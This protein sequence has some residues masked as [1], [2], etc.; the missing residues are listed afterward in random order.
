MQAVHVPQEHRGPVRLRERLYQC[1]NLAP[2]LGLL[3][4]LLWPLLAPRLWL[5]HGAVITIKRYLHEMLAAPLITRQVQGD[6]IQP[7]AK[8]QRPDALN[9]IRR[10]GAIGADE[11]I[12][13][14]LLGLTGIVK[15]MEREGVEPILKGQ[16]HLLKPILR[17]GSEGQAKVAGFSAGV[18]QDSLCSHAL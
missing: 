17:A 3:S 14:Y 2:L 18:W 12:L 11:S 10:Q 7:R 16:N 9:L 4:A 8:L 1:A 6:L 13:H 15:Q 5:K